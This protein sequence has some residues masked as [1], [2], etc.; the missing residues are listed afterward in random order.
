MFQNSHRVNGSHIE[1]KVIPQLGCIDKEG[2]FVRISVTVRDGQ[3][4]TVQMT[5][6]IGSTPESGAVWR[7]GAYQ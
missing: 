3:L 5:A 4:H 2:V 6:G 7:E 1:R